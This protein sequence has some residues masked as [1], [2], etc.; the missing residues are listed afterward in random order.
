MKRRLI[1]WVPLIVFVA[2][3]GF[4]VR[5]LYA[6]AS[7]NIQSAL[8]GQPV[9]EF[10]LAPGAADRP[11]LSSAAYRQGQ[12]RVINIFA[13]WCIPCRAEAGQLAELARAACRS[14]ASRCATG[15]RTSPPF[16]PLMAIPSSRSVR[17]WTGGCSSIS[18][19]PVCRRRSSSTAA[20]SSVTSISARSCGGRAGP[21]RGLGGGAMSFRPSPRAPRA[22]CVERSRDTGD[23]RSVS[24]LRSKRTGWVLAVVRAWWSSRVQP[25]P[26]PS[27][28]PRNMRTSSSPIRARR[29]GRGS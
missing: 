16:S 7:R 11:G 1:L 22:V 10:T 24:R 5:G 18:A 12:P 15:L 27:C 14:T 20:A 6:P 4:I 19:R 3:V 26:I 29:R 13:S 23:G 21:R 28:R 2:I 25:S 9:P 8:I 17:T